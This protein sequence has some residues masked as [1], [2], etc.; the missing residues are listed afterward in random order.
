VAFVVIAAVAAQVQL[1]QVRV[2]HGPL[3]KTSNI[4]LLRATPNWLLLLML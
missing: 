3:R 1:V 2:H 4:E